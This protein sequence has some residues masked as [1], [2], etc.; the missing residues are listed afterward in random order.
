[1]ILK[2]VACTNSVRA[3][4]GLDLRRDCLEWS[5]VPI[6]RACIASCCRLF[7]GHLEST[8]IQRGTTIYKV[9]VSRQRLYVNV[10]APSS[11]IALCAF[12][13]Q[14][15]PSLK[16]RFPVRHATFPSTRTDYATKHLVTSF[17]MY[18]YLRI[19]RIFQAIYMVLPCRGILES[20]K[21]SEQLFQWNHYAID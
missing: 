16:T 19:Y 1:M 13:L 8:G 7:A 3:P 10:S 4:V 11:G 20:G 18:I 5:T 2:L 9:L 17:I 15:Q 12:L 14:D 6:G 21:R